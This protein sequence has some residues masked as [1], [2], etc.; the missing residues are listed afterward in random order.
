MREGVPVRRRTFITSSAAL[1]GAAATIGF[2]STPANALDGDHLTAAEIADARRPDTI[3]ARQRIF[4]V[5]NVDPE[6]GLLPRDRVIVAW[7][8]NSSFALAVTG[9]VVFLDTF[10]TRLE[11]TPGRTPFVL[12]DLVDVAPHAILLGHGHFDHSD[13]AAYLA[14]KT[15][16]TLYASEET[17]SDMRSDFERMSSDPMIQN[18][19]VARFPSDATLN[20]VPVTTTGSTPGTQILRLNI[21]EPFAQTVAFRHLHSISTPYDPTYPH[22]DLIPPDGILPVDPRDATLFPAGTPLPPSDPPLPG[23][24]NIRTG[25]SRGAGG[26]VAIFYNITLRTGSNLSIAWQDTIGALRDG[27]GSAWPDGTPADGKRLTDIMSRMAPV[28]MYSAA[29]GTANFLNNGLRD[30][31]DYQHALQPRM[32]IP[33]HQTTGGAGVGETQSVEQY[34]IYIQQLRDM[35][36]PQSE[37]PDNRWNVDP[38]DYLRPVVFDAST[39]DATT[40]E[41]R[42]A[43]LR[44]FD[45]FPYA[46][47]VRGRGGAQAT[48]AAPAVSSELADDVCF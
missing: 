37:W 31:I 23:Q 30:L 9:R 44:H 28:N 18:D 16:A 1:A 20:L 15:G 38:F 6:T 19:P 25:G 5:E 13:N 46:E 39:P 45:Q 34:A 33:N 35:N 11:V 4:G 17:C 10:I 7:T 43:Q 32:F 27:K 8:S 42:R 12:K 21:L 2:T 47:D 29:V 36:V 26:P 48:P 41:G 22:N 3:A 14:A 40:H 24:L